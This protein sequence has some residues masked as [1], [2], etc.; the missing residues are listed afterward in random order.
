MRK[1]MVSKGLRWVKFL[2]VSV[3]FQ[4]ETAGNG[5]LGRNHSAHVSFLLHE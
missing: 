2:R 1:S 3:S 4:A 5:P